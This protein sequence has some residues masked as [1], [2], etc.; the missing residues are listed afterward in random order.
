MT[1]LSQLAV[2]NTSSLPVASKHQLAD[3]DTD[4]SDATLTQMTPFVYE[5]TN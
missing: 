4:P 5:A 3:A 1:S 2:A